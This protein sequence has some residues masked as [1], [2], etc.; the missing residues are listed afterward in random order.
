MPDKEISPID[1]K[2]LDQLASRR[3]TVKVVR[4]F[5]LDVHEHG[6]RIDVKGGDS[7][8]VPRRHWDKLVRWYVGDDDV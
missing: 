3:R 6:V 5:C 4:G 1:A 2:T 7:L 8:W